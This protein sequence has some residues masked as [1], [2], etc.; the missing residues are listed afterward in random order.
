MDNVYELA[1]E[2][3][4]QQALLQ[5][6]LSNRRSKVSGQ[7]DKVK[8]KPV[9]IK[10]EHKY[11][12][13]YQMGQK[14]IHENIDPDQAAKQLADL[15][16]EQFKQGLW[17][18][19]GADY[20]ILVNKKGK[21]TVLK[22]QATKQAVELSH[23]RKKRYLLEEGT[24]VPFLAELGVMN[25][26]GKVHAA[27]Y[28][29]FRQINRFLEMIDDVVNELPKDRPLTVI[30]FGC[31]KSYLTFAMYHYLV[32]IRKLD[33]RAIGLDLKED[34]ITHCS[35]LAERLDYKNLKFYV[36]D[37]GQYNEV[38]QVDMVV[39]LH[40]C[41]T[42]TDAA[43]EKAVRW[44]AKV[45]LSVPCCQHE[46]F[47]Q[48]DSP[49]LAPMLNHG[50]IK[51]RLSALATDSARARLLELVGYKTQIVEF[52]DMEH[53]PKNLLIRAVRQSVSHEQ[54]AKLAASYREFTQFLHVTPYLEK[55]LK[56]RLE[57]V[58]P[59]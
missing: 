43:L 57:G 30:D 15:L 20:Q 44:G 8:I 23:N 34:V 27:K 22:R 1:A 13:T 46:L 47:T 38:S 35:A 52:I 11:Q 59:E 17:Q 21:A 9:L 40:A 14:V 39:T 56:E 42:A 28:D 48:I 36:G 4:G 50:I 51:E 53:T 45:I 25:G 19:K 7:S 2:L 29:K 26:S 32:H 3:I 49:V 6:T 31:G 5:A 55:A 16:S 41:D 37:I 24:P 12:F 58:L 54:I 33:I 18:A 10:G